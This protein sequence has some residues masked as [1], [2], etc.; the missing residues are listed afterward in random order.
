[1]HVVTGHDFFKSST[2]FMAFTLIDETFLRVCFFSSLVRFLSLSRSQHDNT[3]ENHCNGAAP[4]PN[5]RNS[6]C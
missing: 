2:F 3:L 6:K 5:A 1:M 4:D